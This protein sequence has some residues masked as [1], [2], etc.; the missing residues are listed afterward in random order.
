MGVPEEKVKLEKSGRTRK[1]TKPAPPEGNKKPL[2]TFEK[3]T[4]D[5][6][7]GTRAVEDVSF[8]VN[9]GEFL[10]IVGASGAGKTT[11]LRLLSREFSPSSGEIYFKDWPLSKIRGSKISLLRRHVT[12]IFQDYKLI[13]ERTVWENVTVALEVSRR[14][15]GEIKEKVEAALKQ[16]GI[17]DKRDHFPVQLSGGEAQRTVIARATVVEPDILLADEP[18]ADLDPGTTWEII[19]LLKEINS[20]GKTVIFATHDFDIVDTLEKRVLTL[21][22]GRLVSDVP[23]GKYGR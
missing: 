7:D 15:R 9:R 3:I 2:V 8:K 19:G 17:W 10:F 12:T 14:P 13:D 6:P 16:M 1:N 20:Q 22:Q 18:T 11:L 21:D 23:K 4:K 5:F